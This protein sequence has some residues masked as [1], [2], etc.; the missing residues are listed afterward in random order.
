MF[1]LRYLSFKV[2]RIVSE[3]H[4]LMSKLKLPMK[5]SAIG[6]DLASELLLIKIAEFAPV[7]AR[8]A[9]EVNQRC[10]MTGQ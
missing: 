2:E 3:N 1:C 4:Q 6:E 9:D 7:L 10:K 5:Q 8:V